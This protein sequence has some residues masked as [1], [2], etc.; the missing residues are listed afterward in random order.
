MRAEVMCVVARAATPAQKV[1]RGTVT[2]LPGLASAAGVDP[3]ALTVIG[4]VVGLNL[5]T[6]TAH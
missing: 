1:V 2:T 6:P 4:A 3:P 5:T